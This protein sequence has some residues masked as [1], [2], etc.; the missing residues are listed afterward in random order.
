MRGKNT[1]NHVHFAQRTRKQRQRQNI[2]MPESMT[3]TIFQVDLHPIYIHFQTIVPTAGGDSIRRVFAHEGRRR[4]RDG[5]RDKKK[6]EKIR[7][8][9]FGR[10]WLFDQPL[11]EK[12]TR[13]TTHTESLTQRGGQVWRKWR[14]VEWQRH[15]RRHVR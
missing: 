12:L 6:T 8:G 14:H 13:K 5:E 7:N 15:G 1:A 3:E 9:R 2:F 10:V 4:S 11:G